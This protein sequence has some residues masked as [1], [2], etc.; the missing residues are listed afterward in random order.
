[1]LIIEPPPIFFI[2]GTMCFI[3][4]KWAMALVSMKR[5]Q[6]STVESV[7]PEV[8]SV[9]PIPA[10]FTRISIFLNFLSPWATASIHSSSFVTSNFSGKITSPYSSFKAFDVLVK[11]L[12]VDIGCDYLGTFLNKEGQFSCSLAARCSGDQC[13]FIVQSL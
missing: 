10:L 12:I 4:K 6:S 11:K 13:Y 1:M 3:P 5:C 9:I 8:L 7:K 2:S